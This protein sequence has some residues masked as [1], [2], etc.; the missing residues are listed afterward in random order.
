MKLINVNF[1]KYFM[2]KMFRDIWMVSAN[3]HLSI[4]SSNLYVMYIYPHIHA[5]F[6]KTEKSKFHVLFNISQF[7]NMAEVRFTCIE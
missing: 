4:V 1:R 2:Y 3:P 5:Y 7:S 6:E